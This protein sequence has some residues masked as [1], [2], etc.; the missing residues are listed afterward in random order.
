LGGNQW[1]R[2]IQGKVNSDN[3]EFKIKRFI[4]EAGNI[5]SLGSNQIFSIHCDK[6]DQLWIGTFDGLTQFDLKLGIFTN[7]ILNTK[8]PKASGNFKSRMPLAQYM[9]AKMEICGWE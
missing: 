4:R 7:Q 3:F 6:N 5:N 1:R 9:K 8:N 2:I